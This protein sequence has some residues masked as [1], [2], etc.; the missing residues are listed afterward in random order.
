MA[1]VVIK[2]G[3]DTDEAK[4][5]LAGMRDKL[6]DLNESLKKAK[7]NFKQFGDTNKAAKGVVLALEEEIRNLKGGINTTT[8]AMKDAAE[9]A[10]HNKSS[11]A[12]FATGLNQAL[13]LGMKAYGAFKFVAGGLSDLTT[14][15][16]AQVEALNMMSLKTGISTTELSK[17]EYIAKST[18]VPME[19][20]TLGIKNMVVHAAKAGAP[21]KDVNAAL[22]KE[23]YILKKMGP[24]AA[25]TAHAVGVFGKAAQGLMP[26]L[27]QGSEGIKQM[28]EDAERF[29][30]VV[31]EEAAAAASAFDD[32]LDQLN[33][34]MEGTKRQIGLAVIP[35]LTEIS[36][37]FLDSG[38]D[39]K[40]FGESI[41]KFIIATLSVAM[42]TMR[43]FV[44][45]GAAVIG[46]LGTLAKVTKIPGVDMTALA[47][48]IKDTSQAMSDWANS[49]ALDK[50]DE[51]LALAGAA[52]GSAPSPSGRPRAPGAPGAPPGTTPGDGNK[53]KELTERE[54]EIAAGEA[55]LKAEK[56]KYDAD[57]AKTNAKNLETMN[58]AANIVNSIATGNFQSIVGTVATAFGPE[59]QIFAAA[60]NLLDAIGTDPNFGTNLINGLITT[61][62]ETLPQAI[63]VIIPT[64][65]NPL[66]AALPSLIKELVFMIPQLIAEVIAQ[67]PSLIEGLIAAFANSKFYIDVVKALIAGIYMGFF[68][69]QFAEQFVDGF[70]EMFQRALAQ[71]FESVKDLFQIKIGGGGGGGK[72]L[73]LFDEGT[74]YVPQTGLAVLHKGEA[75]IPAAQN[76]AGNSGGGTLV[77][78]VGGSNFLRMLYEEL[79]QGVALRNPQGIN[80][81]RIVVQGGS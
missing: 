76:R 63:R 31:T 41:A 80:F 21:I 23:A 11:W 3:G 24:G 71:A 68:R 78:N 73:G 59:G 20:L 58:D 16:G 74:P 15:V 26:V 36:K 14:G 25:A 61:L 67:L 5:A 12:E 35:A 6:F 56:A 57:S 51:A 70:S 44:K 79:A 69:G 18:K 13:E 53:P 32:Q 2:I 19:A 34:M 66:I 27:L 48:G 46:F 7:E 62:T 37:A 30:L 55:T 8:K 4:A 50:L 72:F 22:I 54:K 65:I 43:D 77:I 75:V 9:A 29:G 60:F 49:P 1:D 39:A 28:S 47:Q 42:N 81:A 52:V 38:F 45:A 17:L 33:G 10:K 40:G 64:I